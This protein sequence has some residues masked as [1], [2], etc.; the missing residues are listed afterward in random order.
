MV[1][2]HFCLNAAVESMKQAWDKALFFEGL[3]A[4]GYDFFSFHIVRRLK[5]RPG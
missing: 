4:D 5:L 2:R 3:I 1:G